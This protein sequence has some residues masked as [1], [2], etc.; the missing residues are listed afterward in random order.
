MDIARDSLA[1]GASAFAAHGELG[2]LEYTG[3]Y[4]PTDR[5]ALVYGLDLLDERVTSDTRD[6]RK[7]NGVYF[8]YQGQLANSVFVTAGAR[9]D[10][11]DGFGG[12]T[13]S[14]VSAAIVRD[15]SAG[16][17]LKYRASYGTGFRAPS[18]FESA[19][20]RGPFSYPPAAGLTL[21]P[22]QSRGYDLGIDYDTGKG[23][24]VEATLFV[25]R[26]TDEVFF[27]LDT[28]SGYLQS[29]GTS[30][31]R[32]LELGASLPLT[33]RL[34]LLGN[35]T[36]NDAEDTENLQRLRR[37]KRFGNVGVQYAAA[38]KLH[39]LV[40]L[41]FARDAIDVGGIALPDYE[42]L[43]ASLVYSLSK[44]VE[45]FGRIENAADAAYIEAVGFN[46]A[47]RAGY[48]GVRVRF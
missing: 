41:R 37:P 16:R 5:H 21:R 42:V 38:D 31:S 36:L 47:G 12:H 2:R 28:F 43:D 24:H 26:I 15:L 46:T 40:N 25:Q 48:A 45:V 34:D 17:A 10:D 6:R 22:E 1:E 14:R 13:S 30:E 9:R 4:R 11:S 20:D 32:G 3:S 39:L 19:Y 8:E 44:S 18:L 27:D 33:E 7:Q 29:A 23:L 35:L